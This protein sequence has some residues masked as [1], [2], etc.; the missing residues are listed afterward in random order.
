METLRVSKQL[1]GYVAVALEDI[2]GEKV[3]EFLPALRSLSLED[4]PESAV[5]R[6]IEALRNSDCPVNVSSTQERNTE[7]PFQ[8]KS[9]H[10]HSPQPEQHATFRLGNTTQRFNPS[11]P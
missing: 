10:D 6:Y 8:E 2:T 4:Q 7:A 11:E 9:K 1:A 5:G 3:A